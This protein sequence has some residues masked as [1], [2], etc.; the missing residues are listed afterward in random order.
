[1][2]LSRRWLFALFCLTLLLPVAGW[3][4]SQQGLP[5]SPLT[6]VTA[7]GER[8]AFTVELANTEASRE[9]GLMFRR[10]MAPDA[11][12]LFD[13]FTEAPQAFWMKNTYIPLDMLFVRANGEILNIRQRAI[14][15]DES[16]IASDGPV[17]AVLELNG[18]TVA[19]LGIRPGD[20]VQHAIFSGK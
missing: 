4:Q 13:F 14:P 1:M 6:I 7:K 9:R 17:R 16:S 18:G 20:H 2:L 15:Q 19:R 8:H 5:V 10:T 12:M 3:A 11:G